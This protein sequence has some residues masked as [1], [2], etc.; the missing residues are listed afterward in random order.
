MYSYILFKHYLFFSEIKTFCRPKCPC[1]CTDYIDSSL[2]QDLYILWQDDGFRQRGKW[3][4]VKSPIRVYWQLIRT[5]LPLME[6]AKK[7]EQNINPTKQN[8]D[9]TASYKLLRNCKRD[10]LVQS[11]EQLFAEMLL[12]KFCKPFCKLRKAE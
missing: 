4:I 1:F 3:K 12:V 7:F 2:L 5:N 9:K 11:I 8:D 6:R 10:S